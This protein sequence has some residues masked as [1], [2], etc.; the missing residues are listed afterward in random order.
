MMVVVA[1]LIRTLDVDVASALLVVNVSVTVSP[2][3]AHAVFAL[4][5]TKVIGF[6]TGDVA[7]R[8]VALAVNGVPAVAEVQITLEL[9][10]EQSTAALASI[11]GARAAVTVAMV[12]E[13]VARVS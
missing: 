12:L 1:P 8:T 7:A 4:F 2:A 9:F 3:L 13:P 6:R 11:I 10:A 5:E